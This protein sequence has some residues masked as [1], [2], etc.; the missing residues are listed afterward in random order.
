MALPSATDGTTSRN[1]QPRV[2]TPPF[3]CDFPSEKQTES[4]RTMELT[5][6]IYA[7]KVG[8]TLHLI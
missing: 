5:E 3:G 8:V 1:L 4:L 7:F 2:S 6:V